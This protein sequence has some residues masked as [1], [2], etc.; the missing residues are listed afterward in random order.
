MKYAAYHSAIQS[1]FNILV[2]NNN[3]PFME[4]INTL[5]IEAFSS[6][7]TLESRATQSVPTHWYS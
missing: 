3:I 2:N 4:Q 6:F 1:P 5:T 7:R